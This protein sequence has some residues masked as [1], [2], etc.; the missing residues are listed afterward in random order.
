M[1]FSKQE[2]IFEVY[3]ERKIFGMW[4]FVVLSTQFFKTKEAAKAYAEG[5]SFML[6][7][8]ERF[9]LMD[10]TNQE[11]EIITYDTRRFWNC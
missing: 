3:K 4:E 11:K 5:C 1:N 8:N 6:N 10:R 9:I 2:F 7:K